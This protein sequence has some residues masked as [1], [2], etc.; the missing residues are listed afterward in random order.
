MKCI[1]EVS[2]RI[3][4]LNCCLFAFKISLK[5]KMNVNLKSLLGFDQ[6]YFPFTCFNIGIIVES[7]FFYIE[8]TCCPEAS[9]SR[10]F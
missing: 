10:I 2:E 5:Q 9:N 1:I 8:I 3:N 7:H 4:L 6:F